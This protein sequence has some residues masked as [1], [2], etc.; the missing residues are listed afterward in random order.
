MMASNW[1]GTTPEKLIP[2]L[3]SLLTDL[4]YLAAPNRHPGFNNAVTIRKCILATRAVPCLV[5]E[6]SGHPHIKS[7]SPAITSELFYLDPK[8]KL[9]RTLSRWYHF[10]EG[11]L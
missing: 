6:M 10:D 3:R 9:G 2:R 1:L 7:G 11:M 8:L 5:G 4:E